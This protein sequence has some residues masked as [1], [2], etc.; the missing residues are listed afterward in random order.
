MCFILPKKYFEECFNFLQNFRISFIQ[1][2]LKHQLN[3]FAYNWHI[4][5]IS[6][7]LVSLLFGNRIRKR[8]VRWK[9]HESCYFFWSKETEFEG[10]FELQWDNIVFDFLDFRNLYVQLI[11]RHGTE[12]WS[13]SFD[14]T[15]VRFCET[16]RVRSVSCANI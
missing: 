14:V 13:R 15:R 1:L 8:K 9:R 5:A 12:N 6:Q 16:H 4:Y 7:K 3:K 11:S 10:F 2:S